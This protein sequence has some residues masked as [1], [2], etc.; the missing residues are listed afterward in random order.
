MSTTS[1]LPTTEGP[2]EPAGP[3]LPVP[4]WGLGDVALTLGLTIALGTLM[5]LA[6]DAVAPPAHP[7]A[8]RAW[9]SVLL[10]VVP[11]IA[12]AGWPIGASRRKGNGPRRDYGL[13][14]T[15]PHAAIGVA[16]GVAG[17]GAGATVA[18]IQQGLTHST[19][20]SAVGD[21]A[22]STTSASAAAIAVLALCT[23]F[24]APVVEELAF[25]G[26]TYGALLKRGVPPGW[27]VVAVTVV[28][29][30][31][32]FEPG[33]LLVLL[34]IGTSLALV[35]MLTGST[36]ASMVAHMTVNI[37]GAIFIL[38]LRGHGA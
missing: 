28:F 35:R 10:L 14:L 20:S 32:H 31:F 38:T 15:V 19:I 7:G 3:A 37:P 12:L 5:V 29:A 1:V 23:A 11:W 34:T 21:I 18:A 16:G 8:G 4:T 9:G 27:S 17:I 13:T 33:R 6:V 36:A 30:L 25:R 22:A 2:A 26:L 24:G